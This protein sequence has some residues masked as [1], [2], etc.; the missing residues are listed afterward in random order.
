MSIHTYLDGRHP[1]AVDLGAV[2]RDGHALLRVR[3]DG[4]EAL[5][6]LGVLLLGGNWKGGWWVPTGIGIKKA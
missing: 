2:Q 3:L 4:D 1:H 5:W 6:F